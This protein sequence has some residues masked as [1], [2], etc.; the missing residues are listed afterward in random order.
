MREVNDHIGLHPAQFPE[1]PCHTVCTVQ[2]D[3]ANH[4]V[5]QNAGNQLPHGTVGT[6]QYGFHTFTPSWRRWFII[7]WRFSSCMG[8]RGRRRFSLPKP[9]AEM[10]ALTGM[11][12]ASQNRS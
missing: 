12:L 2:A 8:T 10:A 6:A 11:G 4:L 3:A 9:M 7:R 5:P 1:C